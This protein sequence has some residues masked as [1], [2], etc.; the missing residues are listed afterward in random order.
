MSLTHEVR[1]DEWAGLRARVGASAES[2]EFLPEISTDVLARLSSAFELSRFERE[3]LLLLLASEVDPTLGRRFAELT[4]SPYLTPITAIQLLDGS[5]SA[6]APNASLRR[7]N[8]VTGLPSDSFAGARIRIDESVFFGLLGCRTAP[9]ALLTHFR[10]LRG[11]D[12]W[13][14]AH[15]DASARL[16]ELWGQDGDGGYPQVKL[17][18]R[19][20]ADGVSIVSG[21]AR[22]MNLTV[23]TLPADS[24]SGR[25]EDIRDW[26]VALDR[27]SVL[28]RSALVI[29]AHDASIDSAARVDQLLRRVHLPVAILAPSSL[30]HLRG[31]IRLEY[32]DPTDAE[33]HGVVRDLCERDADRIAAAFSIAPGDRLDSWAAVREQKR[34]LL[35][36]LAQRIE[37]RATME[38]LVLPENATGLIR[39]LIDHVRHR[40]QVHTRWGFGIKA[41]Q[42]LGVT[43]LFAGPSGTGKT[44]AAEVIANELG[45]DLWRID[46]SATVSKYIGETEKNLRQIFDH[47]EDSGAVLLFDEADAL[48]GK[49]SEVKDSHDRYANIEVSYLLQRMEAYR[50]VAILTSNLKHSMDPAFMRRLRYV[51]NFPFPDAGLRRRLWSRAFPAAC[52]T[53]GLDVDRLAQLNVTGGNIRN[54]SIGAAF[55]AARDKGP[56]TMIHLKRAARA[57]FAKLDRQVNDAEVAGWE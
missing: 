28:Y 54:I 32:G 25:A 16:A 13:S 8:L 38:D 48:F 27:D 40:Y 33:R 47:A 15:R 55:L 50:G 37:P 17:V 21:A 7:W 23:W 35:A 45:M 14:E 1:V 19:S 41:S 57:E 18:G 31:G 5:W 9:E 3:L 10:E 52:P 4:G 30:D 43:A 36:G 12:P 39:D 2:R 26:A 24:I 11:E 44:M 42:G 29:D 22:A 46:L 49:R 34:A 20:S 56:V 51:V 6:F 53:E